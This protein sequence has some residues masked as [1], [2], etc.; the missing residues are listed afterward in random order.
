MKTEV[1]KTELL[2]AIK[3]LSKL[4]TRKSLPILQ[5]I[6]FRTN[7]YSSAL[8]LTATDLDTTASITIPARVTEQGVCAIAATYLLFY[9]KEL[10]NS[11][12]EIESTYPDG[13]RI[14]SG[15]NHRSTETPNPGDFPQELPHTESYVYAVREQVLKEML[16]LG[17]PAKCLEKTKYAICG[18]LMSAKNNN[19]KSVTT[20]GKQLIIV[21]KQL[22]TA[23]AE[24][25]NITVPNNTI[26]ILQ[27][28]LRDTWNLVRVSVDTDKKRVSFSWSGICVSTKLIEENYPNYNQVIPIQTVAK[29]KLNVTELLRIVKGMFSNP[30]VTLTIT[31]DLLTVTTLDRYE[32]MRVDYQ[33]DTSVT[34]ILNKD[35]LVKPLEELKNTYITMELTDGQSAVAMRADNYTYVLMPVRKN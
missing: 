26:E 31:R 18:T 7:A 27:K 24:E 17:E 3:S 19:L 15:L 14:L 16:T 34:V 20:N 13:V 35:Y 8:T 23:N 10:N 32:T 12:I 30:S 21:E 4:T 5:C 2:Q 6:E 28:L 11:T 22:D 29:F 33:N 1:L 25:N 9:L